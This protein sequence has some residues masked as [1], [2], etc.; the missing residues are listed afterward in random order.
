MGDA[1]ESYAVAPSEPFASPSPCLSSILQSTACREVLV[2]PE[3]NAFDHLCR[4][5]ARKAET[6]LRSEVMQLSSA[7]AS[8]HSSNRDHLQVRCGVSAF[9][10]GSAGG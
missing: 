7:L 8:A 6:E 2:E 9:G 3:G 5:A 10:G 1:A 4:Q